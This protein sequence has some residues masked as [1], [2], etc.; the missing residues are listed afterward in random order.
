[1]PPKKDKKRLVS[2]D[3]TDTHDIQLSDGTLPTSISDSILD[4]IRQELKDMKCCI[5]DKLDVV[6]TNQQSLLSRITKIEDNYQELEK[7]V[8][9]TS[10]SIKEIKAVDE[11]LSSNLANVTTRLEQ[12][13][14]K[15]AKLEEATLQMERYSRSYNIR[16]G[17][18]PELV[19]EPPSYP[20][21]RI[22]DILLEK[23]NFQPELENAHR[24]GRFPKMPTD[25]P[26]HIL[27]K[28]IYR[29]ERQLVLKRC[30]K[31]LAECGIYM[32]QDLPAADAAKKRSLKDVM[33]KAF[34]EGKKP[35]FRNGQLYI[36]GQKHVQK[37]CSKVN[38]PV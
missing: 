29:P 12:A 15:I 7:S 5:Q 30:K 4:V 38:S 10:Q 8:N 19:D 18:I 24:S 3:S 35:N 21:E 27:V 32:I 26:R 28:F 22:K 6:I 31:A 34:Q 14:C 37:T 2:N 17:G 20:H 23:C 25:Q 33:R 36:N 9:Y 13:D 11:S 16:F 1:M